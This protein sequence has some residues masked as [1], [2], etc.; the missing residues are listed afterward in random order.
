MSSE[1]LEEF[2]RRFQ[3]RHGLQYN[4]HLR[5]TVLFRTLCNSGI[6][7][8]L[9][10]SQLWHIRNPRHTQNSVKIYNG[11]LYSEPHVTLAYSDL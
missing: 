5:W 11:V 4:E 8:T 1:R 7:R 10:Y 6:F 2:Q 9:L 3:V